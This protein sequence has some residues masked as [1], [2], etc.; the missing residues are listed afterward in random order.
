MSD[1]TPEPATEALPRRPRP[2]RA[3]Q[4]QAALDVMA[5]RLAAI[6]ELHQDRT[7]LGLCSTCLLSSPCQTQALASGLEQ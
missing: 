2:G 1:P 5:G 6:A 4:E 7:G 3:D